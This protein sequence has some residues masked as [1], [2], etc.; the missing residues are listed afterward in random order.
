MIQNGSL[1]T[2][3]PLKEECVNNKSSHLFPLN[4]DHLSKQMAMEKY[5]CK[6]PRHPRL[7]FN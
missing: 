6:H 5:T 2:K 1:D 7:A 3:Q 4:V